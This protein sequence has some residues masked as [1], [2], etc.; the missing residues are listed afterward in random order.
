VLAQLKDQSA[1][2]AAAKIFGDTNV[3]DTQIARAKAAIQAENPQA[4]N[5]LVR[6]W[7][8]NRL[9]EARTETQ[10]SIELNTPGKFRQDIYGNEA[11][12]TKMKQILPTGSVDDFDNL[13][14]AA[15]KLAST[16]V[17][18]SNTMR[19]TEIG[20]M[21]K[22]RSMSVFKWLTTP[23]KKAIDTAERL[24][25]DKGS[26]ELAAALTD[27]TKVKHIRRILQM[28]PSTQQ[29]LLLSTV[30]GARTGAEAVRDEVQQQQPDSAIFAQ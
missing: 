30:V 14:F 11:L 17:A 15:Q 6:T 4:W 8:G 3:T 23:R 9:N 27:P 1:V 16:P 28:K 21:L 12:R 22:S 18:G 5:D 2:G 26:Q 10:R 7:L 19:D 13:M 25:M 20:N 24:A 29:A